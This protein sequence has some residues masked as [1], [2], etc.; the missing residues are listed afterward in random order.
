MDEKPLFFLFL[1]A[2]S[3]CAAPVLTLHQVEA[4]SV[5]NQMLYSSVLNN[6]VKHYQQ[7]DVIV[8]E[9]YCQNENI[10]D[11]LYLHD[12]TGLRW[13]PWYA[14]DFNL[15]AWREGCRDK[16]NCYYD[17]ELDHRGNIIRLTYHFFVNFSQGYYC[18]EIKDEQLQIV[19]KHIDDLP[20]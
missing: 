1:L 17:V 16:T 15:W 6:C 19:G 10:A 12:A 8:S 9:V 7:R 18:L 11:G 13:F 4:V 3:G 14:P 20:S 5:S 2:L